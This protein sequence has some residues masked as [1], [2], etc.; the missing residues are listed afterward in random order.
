MPPEVS[1]ADC[2][3]KT[4]IGARVQTRSSL[5]KTRSGAGDKSSSP[6]S[7]AQLHSP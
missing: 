6:P 2:V 1:L 5:K 4:R 7:N 3:L